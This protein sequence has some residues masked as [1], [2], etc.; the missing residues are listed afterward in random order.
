LF[1]LIYI[2]NL[3]LIFFSKKYFCLFFSLYS[4]FSINYDF[5]IFF[6]NESFIKPFFFVF[7][8]NFFFFNLI[9]SHI[10]HNFT[11]FLVSI[12]LIFLFINLFFLIVLHLSHQIEFFEKTFL[13]KD[14][15]EFFQKCSRFTLKF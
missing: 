13:K 8:F 10:S 6:S 11:F 14:S 4:N 12:C 9:F 3:K 2:I 7:H 1:L 15:K 5:Q